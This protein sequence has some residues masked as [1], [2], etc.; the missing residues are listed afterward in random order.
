MTSNTLAGERFEKFKIHAAKCQRV[1]FD[2]PNDAEYSINR[3]L[4]C[5]VYDTTSRWTFIAGPEFAYPAFIAR[6]SICSRIPSNEDTP[7]REPSHRD[8][9]P[10]IS[11][12]QD[13]LWC[14]L[15]GAT[16]LLQGTASNAHIDDYRTHEQYD[17]WVDDNW[18]EDNWEE[19]SSEKD[20]LEY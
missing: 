15:S 13:L 10:Y 12:S 20:N 14:M 5:V 16:A 9:A 3:C 7:L 11:C 18:Y 6:L 2:R 4:F 8:S 19:E 17:I 1:N